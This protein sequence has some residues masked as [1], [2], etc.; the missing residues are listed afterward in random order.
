MRIDVSN[1]NYVSELGH[2]K[3]IHIAK[4]E[5]YVQGYATYGAGWKMDGFAGDYRQFWLTLGFMKD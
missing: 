1:S 5:K 2:H 4:G 3:P